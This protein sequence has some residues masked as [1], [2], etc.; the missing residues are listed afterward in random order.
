MLNTRKRNPQ[1]LRIKV[2]KNIYSKY[3]ETLRHIYHPSNLEYRPS[4]LK[5]GQC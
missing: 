4:N 3:H 1:L 5:Y 2:I